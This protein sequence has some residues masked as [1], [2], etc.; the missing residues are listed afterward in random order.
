MGCGSSKNA[1]SAVPATP[2]ELWQKACDYLHGRNGVERNTA[3]FFATLQQAA[4]AGHGEAMFNLGVQWE[5][6]PP[7]GAAPHKDLF[8]A[9]ECYRIAADQYG[10]AYAN[11]ALG[12]CY[13]VGVGV[14]V[15]YEKAFRYYKKSADAGLA[16]GIYSVG[17]CYQVGHG[18]EK[19]EG[20][21]F[22]LYLRAS[23][24]DFFDAHR[25]LGFCYR[26]GIG[27]EPDLRKAIEYYTKAVAGGS[28]QA[29]HNLAAM[30]EKG[31]GM[32]EPDVGRA[33]ELYE[34]AGFPESKQRIEALKRQQEG[35]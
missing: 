33:M 8:K 30:Y 24:M 7:Y 26:S 29:A 16:A 28:P 23:E 34:R 2:E 22:E 3:L 20:K 1:A 13:E 4:N 18:V 5:H 35:S 27:V 17:Y 25:A 11:K 6:G 14:E 10:D 32:D 15:D 12:Y 31:E 19:D 9:V 21:A